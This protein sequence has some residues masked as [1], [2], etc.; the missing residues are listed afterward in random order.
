MTKVIFVDSLKISLSFYI[1]IRMK[2]YSI[3][4]ISC[5][6]LFLGCKKDSNLETNVAYF[7]GEIINPNNGYVMLYGPNEMEDTLFLDDDN[8]FYKKLENLEAGLYTFVHSGE[9]QMVLIEP[10]DSIMARLNTMDFDES[11]VF[12]GNGSKKNNFLI[13]AFLENEVEQQQYVKLSQMEPEAF[14]RYIDSVRTVKLTELEKFADKKEPSELFHKLAETSINYQYY[15]NKEMYPFTYFGH[16]NLNDYTSLP[17]NFYDYRKD[18]DYNMEGLS[19]VYIYNKFLYSHFNNLALDGYYK[20]ATDTASFDRHSLAY[21]L[22]KLQLMDSKIDNKNIKNNLLKNTVRDFLSMCKDSTETQTFIDAYLAKSS[23]EKDKEY[24]K[25]LIVSINNLKP[26][27]TIPAIELIDYNETTFELTKL[28]NRPTV[29]YFW[30]SNLKMHY[31]NSHQ[32]VKSFK[33]KYPNINFIAINVNDNDKKYWKQTLDEFK[34]PTLN[35]F[36]FKHPEKAKQTL[37]LNSVGKVIIID[38]DL[39]II[40]A[41]GNM[42]HSEFEDQLQKL[43]P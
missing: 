26:G 17:D 27:K 16:K 38:K 32:K 42:F 13:N 25:N 40:N 28:V 7:G 23:D 43:Q 33:A 37:V 18:V 12:S 2:F 39:K 24:V 20:N 29:I 31:R 35:E 6:S 19:D 22:E 9:Y 1:F 11:L 41:E 21:N 15:A 8:R 36:Q 10:Q 14:E 30:S 3:L 4:I 5:A 34:F